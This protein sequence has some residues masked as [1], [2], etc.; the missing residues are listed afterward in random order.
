MALNYDPT[1]LL[2]LTAVT[3]LAKKELDNISDKPTKLNDLYS[4]LCKAED[5]VIDASNILIV[6]Q[7]M[8]NSE[9]WD[10][11]EVEEALVQIMNASIWAARKECRVLCH[12]MQRGFEKEEHEDE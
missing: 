3:A 7:V 2:N 5:L 6:T 1:K 8:M 10:R 12:E 11:E 9:K 4:A